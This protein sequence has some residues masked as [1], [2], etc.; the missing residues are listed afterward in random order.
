[1]LGARLIRETSRFINDLKKQDL[2][3]SKLYTVG[4]SPFGIRMCR[5]IGM[6]PIDLPEGVRPDRIPIKIDL[7]QSNQSVQPVE[8]VN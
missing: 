5:D 3:I 2:T 1:M 6:I 8:K 7:R 4:T